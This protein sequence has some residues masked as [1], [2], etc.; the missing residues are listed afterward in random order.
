MV[1]SESLLYLLWYIWYFFLLKYLFSLSKNCCC[2]K[3]KEFTKIFV[4][5]VKRNSDLKFK[6]LRR[7]NLDMKKNMKI[8]EKQRDSDRSKGQKKFEANNER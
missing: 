8:E 3:K 5:L 6:Y 1:S 7:N 2:L 4:A